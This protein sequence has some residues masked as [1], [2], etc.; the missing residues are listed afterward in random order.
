VFLNVNLLTIG[1]IFSKGDSVMAISAVAD[2][3]A[4]QGASQASEAVVAESAPEPAPAPEAVV[5]D[6]PAPE[7]P[8]PG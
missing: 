2:A 4:T 8:I 1:L 3:G 6:A 7:K 5:E